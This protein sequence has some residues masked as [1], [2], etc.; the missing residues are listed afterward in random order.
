MLFRAVV[1]RIDGELPP[2]AKLLMDDFR[3]AVNRAIRAGLQAKVSSRFALVKLLYK[4][5]RRDHPACTPSIWSV[6]SRWPGRY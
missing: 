4:D 1:F 5:F 2:E 3:L 6:R